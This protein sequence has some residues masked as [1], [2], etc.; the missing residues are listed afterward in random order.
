MTKRLA[1]A[2]ILFLFVCRVGAQAASHQRI[3]V[4]GAANLT[5]MAGLSIETI[6]V[7]SDG[8][9]ALE[10]DPSFTF[11]ALYGQRL[12]VS[13]EVP[14]ALK[15]AL[16]RKTSPR[17]AAAVGDPSLALSYT[18][19][20]DDWRLGAELSYSHP[21]GIWNP[22]EA[23]GKNIASGSGYRKIGVSC[24]SVRYMDP[25]IAGVAI[26]ADS[27]FDRKERY[28]SGYRPLVL[29]ASLFATEA[30]NNVVALS[31]GLSQR[32]AWPRRSDESPAEA[33]LS[34]SLSGKLSLVFTEG[35]KTMSFGVSR[36][37]S[38]ASSPIVFAA[39]F[40]LR[41]SEKEG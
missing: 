3:G 11:E 17:V 13:L 5:L 29:T 23:D 16:D 6:G 38:E 24:S 19:R 2:G 14:I 35:R 40:S 18:F 32:F 7:G 22:Y 1:G 27:Y 8:G 26:S 39:G 15:L 30:L 28:E 12:G 41:L 36:L 20:L 25:L 33:G 10:I 4:E 9:A 37:L 31:G 21:L 34:Y